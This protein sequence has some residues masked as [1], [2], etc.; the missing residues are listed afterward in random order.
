MP[1]IGQSGDRKDFDWDDFARSVR[2]GALSG[3]GFGIGGVASNTV[4]PRATGYSDM[5][6]LNMERAIDGKRYGEILPRAVKKY[7]SDVSGVNVNIGSETAQNYINRIQKPINANEINSSI[8]IDMSEAER[9]PILKNMSI[10]VSDATRMLLPSYVTEKIN[11]GTYSE[12]YKAI[13]DYAQSLDIF[14]QYKN[15]NIDVKFN[16]SKE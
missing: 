8:K 4:L 10:K 12:A 13:K 1:L 14:K 2:Q 7:S 9:E 16:F 11:T 6:H 3:L 15:E 5:G